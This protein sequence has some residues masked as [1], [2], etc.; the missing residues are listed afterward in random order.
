MTRDASRWAWRTDSSCRAPSRCRS[1]RP[2]LRGTTARRSRRSARSPRA[3]ERRGRSG[4]TMTWADAARAAAEPEFQF[5][6]G[7]HAPGE[8]AVLSFRGAEALSSPYRLEVELVP[9]EGVR[10]DAPGL[11]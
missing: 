5:E 6:V 10:V 1:A 4:D 11:L 8:L 2:C 3:D 7:P 9:A